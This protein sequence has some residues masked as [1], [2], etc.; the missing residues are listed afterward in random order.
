M[1]GIKNAVKNTSKCSLILQIISLGLAML[2]MKTQ[3]FSTFSLK[4]ERLN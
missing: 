3:W 4:V 2:Q 1:K